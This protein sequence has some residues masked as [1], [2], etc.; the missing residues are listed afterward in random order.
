V[1]LPS[2]VKAVPVKFASVINPTIEVPYKSIALDFVCPTAI[3]AF[4]SKQRFD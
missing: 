1:S 2:N 4:D 3:V